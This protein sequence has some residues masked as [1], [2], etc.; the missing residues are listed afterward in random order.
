MSVHHFDQ[1]LGPETSLLCDDLFS[2]HKLEALQLEDLVLT[3]CRLVLALSTV[4][5]LMGNTETPF[6]T[7]VVE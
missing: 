5:Q 6:C 4:C 2:T 1:P 7:A 3:D